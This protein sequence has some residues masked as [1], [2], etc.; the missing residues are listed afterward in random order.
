MYI[1]LRNEIQLP[2][3]IL[4]C[5]FRIA[6]ENL[7]AHRAAHGHRCRHHCRHPAHPLCRRERIARI[8]YVRICANRRVARERGYT[9][10]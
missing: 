8:A 7:A 2:A 1:N 4:E 5:Y 10:L 3:R 9:V 6:L